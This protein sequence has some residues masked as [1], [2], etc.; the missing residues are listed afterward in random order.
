MDPKNT[1]SAA[2]FY[3]LTTTLPPPITPFPASPTTPTTHYVLPFDGP[4]HNNASA[5]LSRNGA[6]RHVNDHAHQVSTNVL[7]A[8]LNG[9][10]PASLEVKAYHVN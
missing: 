5:K 2:S 1:N 7:L 4:S 8:Q 9:V 3:L 6:N 10:T